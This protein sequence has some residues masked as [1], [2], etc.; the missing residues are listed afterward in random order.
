MFRQLL[1]KKPLRS[2]DELTSNKIWADELRD[3]YKG[4]INRVDTVVGCLRK[5]YLLGLGSRHCF[6]RVHPDGI[7]AAEER[8]F[9]TTEW[10]PKV[11]AGRHGLAQLQ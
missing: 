7:K 11:Y 4:D 6:P 2:F 9:F 1:N 10:T 5:I 3:L 8:P